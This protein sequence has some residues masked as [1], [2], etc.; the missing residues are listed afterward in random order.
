MI[1]VQCAN[2]GFVTE[3]PEAAYNDKSAACWTCKSQ[4][5]DKVAINY[6]RPDMAHT[7]ATTHQP[8]VVKNGKRSKVK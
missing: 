1:R 4:A 3:V 7:R 2:C 5:M 8:E 6:A